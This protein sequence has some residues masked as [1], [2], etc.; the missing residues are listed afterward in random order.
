MKI[1]VTGANGYIGKGVVKRLLKDNLE[2]IATDINVNKV[3]KEVQYIE[4]DLF[5][6]ENP[7][8]FFGNP[9]VLL[10]LAWRDGFKHN[11]KNHI[12]DLEKHCSFIEKMI[13]G[14]IKQVA[15][16]GSMHE[17]GFYEGCIDEDTKTNPMSLY[18]ISKDALRNVTKLIC[19][20]KKVVFQWLRAYY[21][22]G[23]VSSGESIFA[24]L[25]RADQLG[26]EFF[27]F[28]TGEQ[29]YDFIDYDE[30]CKQISATVQ[31]KDI[32]GVIECCTG[33]PIRLG[34]RVERYINDYGLN[35]KLQ[36]GI[37]PT[38]AY[39]SKA[40]WGNNEK[41]EKIMK[42]YSKVER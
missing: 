41:I 21:I 17:I 18:G 25:Y 1:L 9:D 30:L 42:S 5:G 39:D 23:N 35:I 26:E 31:Q 3:L 40:V 4:C 34:E 32:N 15:V 33:K 28:T 2:I 19:N 29:L 13:D 36:Y 11:S 10:H 27:P 37:Y 24:K 38:R 12:L 16:M 20:E 7:M 6:I 22:V 14:G 8:E